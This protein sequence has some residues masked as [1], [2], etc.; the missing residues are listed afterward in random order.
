MPLV[1]QAS[2]DLH[3][4]CQEKLAALT[5]DALRVAAK[6]SGHFPQFAEAELV[7]DAIEGTVERAG[8]GG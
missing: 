5:S 1:P 2:F 6:K 4:R 8:L 7:A 3:L